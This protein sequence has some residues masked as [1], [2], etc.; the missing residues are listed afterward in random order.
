[1]IDLTITPMEMPLTR[2]FR[3][4]GFTLTAANTVVARLSWEGHVGYGESAPLGR[5]GDSVAAIVEFFR[6]YRLPAGAGPFAGERI[7]AGVPRAA[8]CA[9]D[10]AVHDLQGQIL[11]TSTTALL[12]LEGLPHPPTS[13]TVPIEDD[14]ETVLERVRTLRDAPVL[15]VKVGAAGF[16]D[17]ALIEAIRSIYTGAIRLDA[18]EG[19]TAE[20]T[21]KILRE[22]D[23]F[24]IEFCEQPIAAGHPERLRWISD[25][26]P[27]PIMAD[28]DALECAQLG[29]LYGAVYAV[30]VKLAKCGGIG[31]AY[32]MIRAARA[33]GFKVMI[34]CMAES[35]ILATAAAHLGPLADWLDIDG[36]T[37][38]A[39]DPY[40][41]VRFDGGT[42]IMP[43][44]PGLGV[45]PAPALQEQA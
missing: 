41:G 27:I 29:P 7:L 33:L 19:W 4:A 30:N 28:E 26:S 22:I 3:V 31:P 37:L 1:M 35:S 11:G 24:G 34:G 38:L 18:N 42:L 15:K 32:D 14:L 5:Y 36:P 13:L 6:T 43:Q 45:H 17:V 23:R 12:G 9:L 25:R 8:R 39:H 2:T 21:V 40:T 44:G 20:Q 16:D 10:I